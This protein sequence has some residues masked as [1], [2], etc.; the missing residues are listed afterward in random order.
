MV[1][2]KEKS[3]KYFQETPNSGFRKKFGWAWIAVQIGQFL[4]QRNF[5]HCHQEEPI[6]YAFWIQWNTIVMVDGGFSVAKTLIPDVWDC[7]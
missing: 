1:K 5:V 6:F 3:S 7:V 2:L 4:F